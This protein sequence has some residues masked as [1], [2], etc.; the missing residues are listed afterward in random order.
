LDRERNQAA[1]NTAV[2]AIAV[3][4]FLEAELFGNVSG[5]E[6]DSFSANGSQSPCA[7]SKGSQ[8]A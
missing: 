4:V 5:W 2:T 1:N 3:S 7:G 8:I 6:W